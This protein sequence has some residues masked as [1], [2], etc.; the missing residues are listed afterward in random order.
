MQNVYNSSC[1][2]SAVSRE[3]LASIHSVSA[4]SPLLSFSH[5][6]YTMRIYFGVLCVSFLVALC[7]SVCL[8]FCRF[9]L[10][11]FPSQIEEWVF[12]YR[13]KLFTECW[14]SDASVWKGGGI[15]YRLA[16]I[17]LP[18]TQRDWIKIDMTH[19]SCHSVSS[20][21]THVTTCSHTGLQCL[22]LPCHIY[23][24]TI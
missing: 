15:P 10:F 21:V 19:I 20:C 2:H 14:I 6:I 13:E 22:L 8:V 18:R 7:S 5:A 12:L 23:L 16:V 1:C 11:F 9:V 24:Y 3:K 17:S 4:P